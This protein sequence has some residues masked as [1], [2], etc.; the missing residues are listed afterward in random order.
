[1]L[2]KGDDVMNRNKIY[3]IVEYLTTDELGDSLSFN[4]EGFN[5]LINEIES[6]GLKVDDDKLFTL[7][8]Y[9]DTDCLKIKYSKEKNKYIIHL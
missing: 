3:K 8:I 1:M 7:Y 9:S 4:Y 6:T 5:N 2:W